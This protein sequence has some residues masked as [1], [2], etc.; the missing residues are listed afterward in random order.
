MRNAKK[1]T[2]IVILI[3]AGFMGACWAA[4]DIGAPQ[5][6]GQQRKVRVVHFPKDRSLGRIMVKDADI[7][8]GNIQDYHDWFLRGEYLGEAQGDVVIPAGKK[9]ALFL[10]ENALKDSSPL[11][12]LKPDDLYM[13]ST[14][15]L[16][17][18]R[19]HPLHDKCMSHIA[20]LAGLKSL[21]LSCT[22]ATAEGMKHITKLQSLEV[23]VPP[24]GLTNKG[25][26]Y[27]AQLK[28][29]KGLYLTKNRITNTGLKRF[30]PEL[31][32]LERL[33]LYS[34]HINDAG[35]VCLKDL[36]RLSYLSLNSGNFNDT[37]LSHLKNISTL[38]TLDLNHLPVTDEGLRHVSGL[39]GLEDLSLY[40]TEVTDG[41][42]AYLKSMPF[43]KKLDIKKRGQ[44][45]QI[46][47]AGMEHLAQ[48]NSLEHL[49]LP[50]GIT[51]KGI[52][53]IAKLKNLK[54]LQGG[55]R[56]DIALEHISKLQSLEYLQ[57]G[58]S[59]YTDAGM[60]YLAKL[61]NLRDLRLG[62][63]SITNEGLAK[64]KTLKS[65]ERLTLT[66]C[67]KVTISG[68]SGLNALNNLTEL[69]LSKGIIQ[70]NS[71]LDI[72]GLTQLEDLRLNVDAPIC[73]NDLACL[74]KLK[75]LRLL[76]IG[77][78]GGHA[79]TDAGIAHLKDLPNIRELYCHSP[80][81]TDKSL[82]YLANMKTLNFLTIIG[83]F[84]DDGLH[85]LEQ[86][87]TLRH[88]KIHTTNK[89]SPAAIQ[90]LKERLPNLRSFTAKQNRELK[91]MS[92][93]NP[94][95]RNVINRRASVFSLTGRRLSMFVA[96]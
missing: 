67:N 21:W 95:A 87:K 78:K 44:K 85:N 62:A 33:G 2:L 54:H 72:S 30:L 83:N 9:A 63:D 92:E 68:L 49:E 5:A 71:G 27:V 47:D 4:T 58:S 19:K 61:T 96:G 22:T 36:P 17:W 8:K 52:A 7:I 28:S 55:G 39:T 23:L 3:C 13:L 11:L 18:N 57:T 73:D 76:R 29:L 94:N 14:V 93:S 65:L 89:F 79:F 69:N 80:Y 53:H 24:K 12:N 42:L 45:D 88:L 77:R 84:T 41:G 38:K 25:L 74:K 82:S 35:L 15:P 81:L 91:K 32:K 48:I 46:T 75:N 86:L 1:T 20:H 56:T 37:G 59:G 31:T 70:D 6:V 34:G 90:Q 66:K 64:L 60:D 43:L 16:V 10:Y 40:N 26:S 50:G 51:D